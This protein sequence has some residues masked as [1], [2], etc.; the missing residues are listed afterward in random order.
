MWL[1][2]I[3]SVF[4]LIKR[5]LKDFYSNLIDF[6][7]Q[8]ELKF[9]D[10]KEAV[11]DFKELRIPYIWFKVVLLVREVFTMDCNYEKLHIL[12]DETSQ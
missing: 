2:V 8:N 11:K 4:V 9:E 6:R 5:C 3:T 10:F 12:Y 1:H 7:F